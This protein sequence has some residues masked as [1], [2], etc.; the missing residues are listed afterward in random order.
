MPQPGRMSRPV[1]ITRPAAQ[2][3]P[4]A[5]RIAALGREAVVFPLLDIR[6]LPDAGEL[7]AALA[8]LESF[9]L[10]AFVSPNAID[11]VFS[12]VSQWPRQVALAVMGEGSRKAL[13]RHGLDESNATIFRP[14]DPDRTDS[15][16]LLHVLDLDA[17]RGKRVMIVRGESG[18]ELLADALREA[19]ALVR[20]VPAYRRCAPELDAA[21]RERLLRLL[22][23]PGDWIIT[24]S[25]ALQILRRLV[26]Q[27]AGAA[28]V[29]KMQQQ[30]LLIPHARIAETAQTLGFRQIRLSGPGDEG[31]LAALQSSA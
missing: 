24:S 28:G 5:E 22:E 20:Q 23:Q 6:P 21:G 9:A 17:L 26:E 12:R 30:S 19:G 2:A 15:Q 10:V 1:V 16:T 4:L 27:H 31:L 7:Q 14:L 11:A 8:E 29:A 18:R 3:G 13:A 25:E